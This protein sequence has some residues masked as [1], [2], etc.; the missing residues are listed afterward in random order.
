MRK[1][2]IFS[3]LAL[4]VS[5]C[6][7]VST[8]PSTQP[9]QPA[10]K[11]AAYGGGWVAACD[12]RTQRSLTIAQVGSSTDTASFAVKTEY[13][14]NAGCTG[15][16][17]ATETDSA[18]ISAVHTGIVDSSYVLSPGAPTVSAKVDTLSLGRQASSLLVTGPGVV[19]TIKNGQAQWCIELGGG[20][21]TCILDDGVSP[22]VSG[23]A[24][25]LTISSGKM[26]LLAPA[27]SIYNITGIFSK[28]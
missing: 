3:T 5:A 26:Y 4:A 11:L 9:P 15:A 28:K 1:H 21:S 17:L 24:G 23:I 22:P 6:G 12:R 19:R 8:S 25:G 14:T 2:L 20:E 27:G 13:F 18:A 7:G 10:F 16:V